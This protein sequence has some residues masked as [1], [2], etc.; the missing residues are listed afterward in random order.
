LRTS[1]SLVSSS[2]YRSSGVPA[3][4]ATTR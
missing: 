3:G 2:P 1:A 4:A